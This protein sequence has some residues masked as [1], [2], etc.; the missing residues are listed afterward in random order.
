MKDTIQ[1]EMKEEIEFI[2]IHEFK[3]RK[4]KNYYGSS[5]KVYRKSDVELILKMYHDLQYL[6]ELSSRTKQVPSNPLFFKSKAAPAYNKYLQLVQEKYPNIKEF[7][8]YNPIII[9]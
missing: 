1:V 2:S 7:T 3:I 5:K 6:N 4:A 9:L 8:Y